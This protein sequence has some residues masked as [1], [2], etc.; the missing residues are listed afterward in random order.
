MNTMHVVT[1]QL[2]Q[3]T[4]GKLSRRALLLALASSVVGLALSSP[5]KVAPS[6]FNRIYAEFQQPAGT[7][8]LVA[9][10]RG[11]SGRSTGAWQKYPENSLAAIARQ[12]RAGH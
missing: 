9:A 8:V 12:H 4:A 11:L 5:A 3:W 1:K 10:H 2:S 7:K 6:N